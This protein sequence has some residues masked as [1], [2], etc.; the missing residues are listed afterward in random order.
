[1]EPETISLGEALEKQHLKT[2]LRCIPWHV[3]APGLSSSAQ[4]SP[5]FC[6]TLVSY[7]NRAAGLGLIQCLPRTIVPLQHSQLS[8]PTVV[9]I[10][11]VQTYGKVVFSFLTQQTQSPTP[12]LPFCLM[13]FYIKTPWRQFIYTRQTSKACILPAGTAGRLQSPSRSA[14]R[15]QDFICQFIQISLSET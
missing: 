11:A 10:S 1:M 14:S 2:S 7:R 3:H 12:F 13:Q 5:H 15:E 8:E 4:Q 6:T 9:H